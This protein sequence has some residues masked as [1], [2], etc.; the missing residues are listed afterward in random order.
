VEQRLVEALH[1]VLHRALGD[2]IGDVELLDRSRMLSA[3][4][5]VLISTSAA[6]TRPRPSLR[7][8]R[9]N[10]TIAC[11]AGGQ[12][13]PDLVVLMR[14]EKRDHALTSASRRSCAAWRTP[15]ARVRALSAVSSV[16]MSR[17]SPIRMRSGSWRSTCRSAELNVRVSLPT[18]RCEDVG[19]LVAMQ[20][21]D[22][23]LDRDDVHAPVRVHMIDHRRQGRRFPGPRHA[24][25]RTRP[26]GLSA[27]SSITPGRFRSRICLDLVR[28]SPG[29]RM[30]PCRA[31]DK[32][33]SGTGRRPARR[34][35][36]PPPCAR[37]T[38]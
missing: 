34:S 4:A 6:G 2:E 32:R 8:T 19:V 5:A 24:V 18:S 30:P 12:K 23:V 27:I 17:I 38:P 20:E 22:R 28:K 21:L 7:G 37:R 1:A 15:C 25:T 33:W 35:R 36:S 3:T 10:E 9:R 13:V 29:T 26:R 31:A 14:R 16:S 11:S